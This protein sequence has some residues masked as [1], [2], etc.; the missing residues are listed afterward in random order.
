MAHSKS[1]VATAK[2]IR[3]LSLFLDEKQEESDIDLDEFLGGDDGSDDYEDVEDDLD[4]NFSI[5]GR[6]EGMYQSIRKSF[7]LWYPLF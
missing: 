5:G 4:S 6:S 2:L 3:F 1:R 7:V